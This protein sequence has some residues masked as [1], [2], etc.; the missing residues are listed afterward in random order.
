MEKNQKNAAE[1]K[2][3][4][5]DLIPSNYCK[6]AEALG[7]VIDE[8]KVCG[9]FTFRQG[10]P[11]GE[12]YSFD[13]YAD[14]DF[15]DGVAAAVRRV[16]DDFDIDEHV[17]LFAE[18]SMRGESG[19]PKLSILVDDAKE[20]ERCSARWRMLSS[21]S[22]TVLKRSRSPRP[23]AALCAAARSSLPIRSSTLTS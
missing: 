3:S 11:A 23:A 16:Y 21:I 18:A 15:S 9:V 12:D 7:W 20:I 2:T 17:G 13:L 1:V 19:V 22:S 6:K 4:V 8:D 14:D 10:S 5:P